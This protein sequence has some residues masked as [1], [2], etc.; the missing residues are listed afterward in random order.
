MS[1]AEAVVRTL[2]LIS[3]V[4]RDKVRVASES[5]FSAITAD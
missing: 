1:F 4:K 2:L 3:Y 5:Y